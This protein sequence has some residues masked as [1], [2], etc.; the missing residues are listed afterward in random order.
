MTFISEGG[1]VFKPAAN[2][3]LSNSLLEAEADVIY[4]PELAE[5]VATELVLADVEVEDVEVEVGC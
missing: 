3:Q 4:D 5:T 2:S 1:S